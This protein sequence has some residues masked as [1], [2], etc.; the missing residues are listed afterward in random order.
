V[1][2]AKIKL[3]VPNAAA[4][5]AY[6]QAAVWK[7]FG[8]IVAIGGRN[9]LGVQTQSVGVDNS[10]TETTVIEPGKEYIRPD[11]VRLSAHSLT[12]VKDSSH[13]LRTTIYPYPDDL[14]KD[15]TWASS[16]EAVATVSSNG[17]VTAVDSGSATIIVTTVWADHQDSC[18][19][20]V[21][22][23]VTEIRL[24]KSSNTLYIG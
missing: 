1:N 23:P 17:V 12:L 2:L 8:R 11:S 4:A 14:N 21:T 20:M 7:G 5:Y 10:T 3:W 13:T 24:N 18:T 6:R 22:S 16:N 19:V 15:V 9:L